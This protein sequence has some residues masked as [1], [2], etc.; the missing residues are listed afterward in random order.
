MNPLHRIAAIAASA[1]VPIAV[2]ACSSAGAS[3][4][5]GATRPNA[6]VG[7]P[8]ADGAADQPA[9]PTAKPTLVVFITVDQLRGDYLTRWSKQFTGGLHRFDVA[10]AHFTQA[11][12][13]HA[14]TE[15]APGHSVT[16]SGRF[17]VH[18]GITSNSNGV[19][20]RASPLIGSPD[21]GAS[22]KRFV[23]TTLLDWMRAKDRNTR[24]LSVSR[25]DRAAIL[26][27]G[28]TKGDVYWYAMQGNFT[29][30]AYY[31]KS[32]P[33]WVQQFNER[34]LPFK[35]RNWVWNPLLPDSAYPEPDS[36]DVESQGQQ[37]TFPHVVYDDD[38]IAAASLGNFP[39]M[40]EL[41]LQF[42]LEGLQQMELGADP[43]RTDL[44][45]ISLSTTDAVG[46][47]YGPD[48]KELHDQVL[49]V[50]KFLGAFVDS[51]FKLRDSTRVIL[52][53]TGDHGMSPFP[54]VLSKVTPNPGAQ[55]VDPYPV[56]RK[57]IV[58][59]KELGIDTTQVD[60]Y[61]GLF[62]VGDTSS[63]VRRKIR[64]DSVADALNRAMM[65]VPGVY[66]AD[67]MS[68]LPRADTVTDAFARRW[69]HMFPP[70][71]F[72]RSV[73]TLKQFNYYAGIKIA[74]HG[75]PW[76][77]DAWVPM[78]FWGAPF[79]SGKDAT[80]VRVVDMAPTLAQA[81]GV[82]PLEKLDGVVL[83]AAFRK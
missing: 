2:N 81:I 6:T 40:D 66:R 83:P 63:F 69:L 50:D 59:M 73:L 11:Y 29:T 21:I 7:T 54:G 16:M 32:L 45:N 4:V 44:L 14:I 25:K 53:L 47:R 74:T 48:S 34:K 71:G 56:W 3:S 33:K 1:L 41:T 78:I 26:P 8:S 49:Y 68:D 75:S 72:V 57:A 80:R 43:N 13:D 67:K 62:V 42:A 60:F 5:P 30:S 51:L 77:Q 31:A 18:T 39:V 28:R 46:H 22:P 19:E 37:F 20:D 65:Q 17:P 9:Q 38:A 79:T 70:N 12:H 76:D 64:V 82:S 10:G 52:T 58:R 61:E 27:I 15:T 36:V 24:F 35:Y 55:Y 23:G